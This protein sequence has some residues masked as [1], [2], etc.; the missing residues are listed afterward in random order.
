V[1]TPGYNRP[2][3]VAAS[4]T[5]GVY[6]TQSPNAGFKSTQNS[7]A[8]KYELGNGFTVSGGMQQTKWKEIV[9]GDGDQADRSAQIATLTYVTGVHTVFGT[10]GTMKEKAAR[11]AFTGKTSTMTAVGYNY[12]LS[13]TSNLYGRYETLTDDAGSQAAVWGGAAPTVSLIGT[14]S[15]NKRTRTQL[16]LMV[17]F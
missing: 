3:Y 12:A 7:L 8:A 10:Y 5:T 1:F 16:G 11:N 9:A 2:C 15:T 4:T 13:K 6:N 14:D 17:N